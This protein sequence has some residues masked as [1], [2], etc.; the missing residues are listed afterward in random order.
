VSRPF[1]DAGDGVELRR[2]DPE[3]AESLQ[4]V[5]D[6]NRDRLRPWMWWADGSTVETTRAFIQAA[7]DGDL[8]DPV[9]LYV[10]GELVGAMGMSA[11]PFSQLNREIG[12]WIESSHE[13]RGIV[14]RATRAL[15]TRAFTEL[16]CHRITIH[17]GTANTRSR[18]I[19]ERLGFRHEG[20]L[21]ESGRNSLGYF[22]SEVYGLL[23][24]EW[25]P[26]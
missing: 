20:T 15:I 13:G 12:Y 3:D 7:I 24:N 16:G 19:P 4:E 10:D 1:L 17:A 6:R 8:D 14:T 11:D 26:S 21:R 23:E 22:D 18:A 9:G 2:L 25:P 5:I